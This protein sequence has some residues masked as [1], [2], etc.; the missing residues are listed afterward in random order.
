[1]NAMT[2]SFSVVS[3][4]VAVGVGAAS[5]PAVSQQESPT[6]IRQIIENTAAPGSGIRAF[7]KNRNFLPAWSPADAKILRGVLK[8]SADEGLDPADYWTPESSENAGDDIALT[9][10]ALRYIRDVHT[11]R[12]RLKSLDDD[13]ALP[14][15][16]FDAVTDLAEALKAH[17]LATFLEN[18]PPPMPEYADL[19]SALSVYRAIRARGGWPTLPRSV[20]T[21][22]PTNR[23]DAELLRTRL[24]DEYAALAAKPATD[25]IAALKRFQARHGLAVDGRL[26]PK[27][28][29]ALNVSADTRVGQII[30]NMERWRWLPRRFEDDYIAVN[31]PDATLTLV[32]KKH[33][34]LTS[35]VV[36]GK[37][38]SPTPILRSQSAGITVNPPWNVP[39]SIARKE[40]LPKLKANP[41]YLLSEDMILLD[42]PP[43]DPHGLHVRWRDIPAN[44]FPYHIQQ[45]PGRRNALGTVKIEFPNRF[46][47]YLHDTPTKSAFARANRDVSH[48]CVR[49]QQILPL[50]SYALS[51]NLDAIITISDAISTRETRYLPL[52]KKLPVYFLYWTA[53]TGPNGAVEF[54]SDIYGRDKRMIEALSRKTPLRMGALSNCQRG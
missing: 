4:L 9:R 29:A 25:L 44:S 37:P 52:E 50:A 18:A 34:V 45:H 32:L 54:R 24:D 53:F 14:E 12:P 1:M 41:R 27:T 11:G 15:A 46:D 17:R 19:K 21:D 2:R 49:V 30:A 36:V 23:A 33:I 20:M 39:N 47:I 16:K 3:V 28:F 40:I 5:I 38:T 8:R 6:A 43:G 48:G 7:Y 22:F 10:A 13:V 42:G 26:G 31:V 51:R 35:R